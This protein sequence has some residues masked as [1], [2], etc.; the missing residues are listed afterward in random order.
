MYKRSKYTA[1]EV[2]KGPNRFN[3]ISSTLK[4]D[5]NLKNNKSNNPKRKAM[6]ADTAS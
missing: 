5:I 4:E 2:L 1:M 3:K 6:K